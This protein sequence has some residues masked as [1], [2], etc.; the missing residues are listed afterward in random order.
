MRRLGLSVLILIL[1]VVSISNMNEMEA[2]EPL[3][4]RQFEISDYTPHAPIVIESDSDF[5]TQGWTG[6]GT[7]QQPYRIEN[8]SIEVQDIQGYCIDIQNV[9]AHFIVR[10]C[11]LYG[12][13]YRFALVLRNATNGLIEENICILSGGGV[14]LYDC[15]DISI[16]DNQ[17]SAPSD[18]TG[19]Y[20][21]G[22]WNTSISYNNCSGNGMQGI[23]IHSSSNN[24]VISNNVCNNN[25]AAG[26]SVYDCSNVTISNSE[27]NMNLD[28]IRMDSST[29][30]SYC[31][32]V[33]NS[34]DSNT[35][36]GFD[37]EQLEFSLI[38]NNTGSGNAEKML[39]L[40]SSYN[41][42]LSNNTIHGL[43]LTGTNNKCIWN[44]ISDATDMTGGNL[45][46]YN[47]WSEY[48]GEDNNGDGIGDTPYEDYNII[49]THPLMYW[50][51]FPPE[52][53]STTTTDTSTTTTTSTTSTSTSTTA[54]SDTSNTITEPSPPDT[55][56]FQLLVMYAIGLSTGIVI[57]VIVVLFLK[58]K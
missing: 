37:L 5:E 8:L 47:Y 55:S 36:K 46:E 16:I 45:Y 14:G 25:D 18:G 56:S 32:V 52:P 29:K 20:L 30:L 26:I 17:C 24:T 40:T 43:H 53:V 3:L 23:S 9:R 1:L 34:C 58:R 15:W 57:L 35:R 2:T 6:S 50:P 48:A 38:K 19:I 21:T 11:Y 33:N 22:S 41:V 49:D 12:T 28:G 10:N 4:N 42:T 7:P 27:C 31:S 51:W 44:A 39:H 54:T 13:S